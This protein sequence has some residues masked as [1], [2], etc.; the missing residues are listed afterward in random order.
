M[1]SI[2][3]VV[4]FTK[5]WEGGLSR[6]AGD[7][8]SANPAP[9]TYK[10]LTGWHTNR[11]VTFTSFVGNAPK[12]GYAVTPE[13]FFNMPDEIWMKIAKKIYWDGLL[14]DQVRSEAVAAALFNWIWGSGDYGAGNSLK[15]YLFE[16]HGIVATTD[17]QQVEAINK[18][19]LTKG[20]QKIF[21]ELIDWREQFFRSIGQP[22]N[23][24][25][26]LNRLKFGS[27]SGANRK[28]SMLELGLNLIKK[29]S[30]ST[31][32]QQP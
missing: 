24:Q 11:G 31:E 20:E 18:L 29:K 9:W 12:L 14:L 27:G 8:A 4:E 5:A 25:G 3:N 23:L 7:K 26:W 2:K 28:I 22:Q 15:K 6:D 21:L 16:K 13:N 30:S 32:S 10:G 17:A 1:A 19:T